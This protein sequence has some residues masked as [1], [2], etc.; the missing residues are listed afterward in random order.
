MVKEIWVR[1]KN[2][3]R[4]KKQRLDVMEIITNKLKQNELSSEG[5]SDMEL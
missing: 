5:R 2:M 3:D 1:A 4:L